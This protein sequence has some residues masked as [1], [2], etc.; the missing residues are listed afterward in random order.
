[1]KKKSTGDSKNVME[2]FR[3]PTDELDEILEQIKPGELGDFYKEYGHNLAEDRDFYNYFK[4]VLSE[5]RIPLKDVYSFAGVS[6][7]LGG[8]I[9]RMEKHTPDRD[10]ILRFCVAGHFTKEETNRA[11]KLYGMTELYGRDR[12]DALII[13]AI[14]NRKYRLDEIDDLLTQHGLFPLS[15][16]EKS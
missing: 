15:K 5:K 6:E 1:M 13:V 9:I 14:N 2:R 10:Q 7:S 3:K 8:Q 4:R 11:L 12:R 16:P